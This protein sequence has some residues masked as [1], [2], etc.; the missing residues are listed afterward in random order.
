MGKA[1][2]GEWE[3]ASGKISVDADQQRM[4]SSVYGTDTKL[5]PS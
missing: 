1:R 4:V 2:T 3:G 5:R